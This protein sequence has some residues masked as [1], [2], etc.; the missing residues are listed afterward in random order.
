[1][2]WQLVWHSVIA[3]VLCKWGG[4]VHCSSRPC[5]VSDICKQDENFMWPLTCSHC[6]NAGT[7][8][9]VWYV[10]VYLTKFRIDPLGL[11]FWP[12]GKFSEL[13]NVSL[14][15]SLFCSFIEVS[16]SYNNCTYLKCTVLWALIYIYVYE[17]ITRVK[18]MNISFNLKIFLLPLV[19]P[20]SNLTPQVPR[21]TLV[22][23]EALRDN[24]PRDQGEAARLHLF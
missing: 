23:S 11:A 8:C 19:I 5:S 18:K 20:P 22:C 16:F 15:P 7:C 3:A 17:T 9:S 24:G 2:I 1:M 12:L 10:P 6:Q 14:S 13:T 4:P 21:K